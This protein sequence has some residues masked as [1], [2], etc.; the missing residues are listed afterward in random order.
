[1]ITIGYSTRVSN[2]E[3]KKYLQK[4]CMFKEVE[5]IEKVNNG[6]KSLSEVYN[7]II[8]ESNNNIIVL[9]HDDIEFD[10]KNWGEKL[11]RN[12]EKSEY[13]I[14]GLAGGTSIPESGI[15]WE[16][17]LTMRG[18]VNHQKDGKKWES[19]YSINDGKISNTLFVDGLFIAFD[20][21]KIKKEFDESVKGFHFYDLTFSF[22][23][24][25]EGV[26]VGVTYDVRVTHLSI[27]ETNDQWEE[28]R[29]K[30]VEQFKNEIPKKMSE[31]MDMS[32]FIICHDQ[33]I[34]KNN[35][36]SKKFN[37]LDNVKFLY[38]GKNEFDDIE[39]YPNVIIVRDLKYNI[40]QYPRF[41]AFTAWYAIWKN[42]L[43]STK[44]LNLLEY[45]VNLNEDFNFFFSNVIKMKPKIISYFPLTMRNYHYINNPDW[46]TSISKGIKLV[47]KTDINNYVTGVIVDSMNKNV[48]PIWPTTN[49]VCFEYNTFDKYMKWIQPLI[50]YMK[51]DPFSGHNQERALSFFSLMNKIPVAYFQGYIEHVQA[52][53]HK[54]QGHEVTNTIQL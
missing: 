5:V 40:E 41:T 13:G 4:T 23:N 47:Y 20:K 22:S 25:L 11:L 17:P 45:D 35:I 14:I 19:K 3:Y 1:M 12:F 51:E 54:T 44:Y 21:R 26:K 30:F 10:T 16:V 8:K 31:K 6:E 7:E 15:W 33:T 38:V 48:E 32:T 49:N 28:N 27:G 2:P 37:I 34:I 43:C 42:N 46:I 18:I 39:L 29:K 24:F 50:T 9:C 36:L 53:S 52:D